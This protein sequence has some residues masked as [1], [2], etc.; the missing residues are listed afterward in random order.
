MQLQGLISFLG[1]FVHRCVDID[2]I[3]G[4]QRVHH[5]LVQVIGPVKD[6]ISKKWREARSGD[7]HL[8][9]LVKELRLLAPEGLLE[10]YPGTDC[11]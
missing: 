1:N 3:T 9:P 6:S 4:A 10:L 11:E 5:Y 2:A 7:A 8:I